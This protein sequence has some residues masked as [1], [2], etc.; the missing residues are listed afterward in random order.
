MS[1][2]H[3]TLKKGSRGRTRGLAKWRSLLAETEVARWHGEL[4]LSSLSTAEERLRVLARYCSIVNTTPA[5]LVRKSS[6]PNGG[7]RAVHD[8]LQDFVISLRGS[9][10]PSDHG[11]DDNDGGSIV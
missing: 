5:E 3:R 7:R 10:K 6:D 8:Q 9:H 11:E 2:G 4:S 1:P